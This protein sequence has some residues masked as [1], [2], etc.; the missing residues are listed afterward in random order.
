MVK[1][2][3]SYYLLGYTASSPTDG[4]FKQIRVRIKRRACR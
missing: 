1:D 2:A 3:S 4:R